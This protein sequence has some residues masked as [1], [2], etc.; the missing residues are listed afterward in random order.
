VAKGIE[1]GGEGRRREREKDWKC[2]G[3]GLWQWWEEIGLGV[4]SG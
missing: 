2:R 1:I 4:E 3:E